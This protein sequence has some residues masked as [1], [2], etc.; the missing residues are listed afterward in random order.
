[1]STVSQKERVPSDSRVCA[2]FALAALAALA[3]MGGLAGGAVGCSAFRFIQDTRT[4]VEH[5]A[6]VGP[7]L[8]FSED[9][10]RPVIAASA[11]EKV[12]PAYSYVAAPAMAREARLRGARLY[13]RP[14]PGMTRETLQHSLECHQAHVALGK[15]PRR[16]DDPYFL[17]DRWVD[18]DTDSS[19]GLFAVAVQT[20][21][22][23]NAKDI[24]E[25][26]R[27]FTT[28]SR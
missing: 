20:V 17:P 28:V 5:A 4:P 18:I 14:L 16:D 22:F 12:E 23:E 26:A 24:L 13:L 15:A 1:M 3:A 6:D 27:R 9:E 7:C 25:R 10:I 11:V 8:G 21:E 2:S 19:H